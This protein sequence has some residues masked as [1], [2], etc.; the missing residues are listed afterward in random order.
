MTTTYT[1]HDTCKLYVLTNTD[2]LLAGFTGPGCAL[3]EP[4]GPWG[5][6]FA[7]RRLES[8]RFFIQIIMLGTLDFKVSE[9]MATLQFS[10]EYNLDSTFHLVTVSSVMKEH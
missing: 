2:K 7:L 1:L 9:H 10:L 5:I 6:T 3:A 8:L 4:G